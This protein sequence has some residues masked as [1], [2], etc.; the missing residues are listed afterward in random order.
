[1]QATAL[2]NEPFVAPAVET[3]PAPTTVELDPRT[4]PLEGIS[5]IEASAGT[6]KTYNLTA[7]VVRF[8]IEGHYEI[9]QILVVTFTNAATEELRGRIRTRLRDCLRQARR[10]RDSMLPIDD[11]VLAYA[12]EELEIPSARIVRRLDEALKGFDES[13]TYTIHSFCQRMLQSNAFES[14]SLFDTELETDIQRILRPIC[15]DFWRR[16]ITPIDPPSF[17]QLQDQSL[18]ANAL[19]KLAD[20]STRVK[21]EVIPDSTS[22]AVQEATQ[23]YQATVK[24]LREEWSIDRVAVTSFLLEHNLKRNMY[25]LAMVKAWIE[26]MDAWLQPGVPLR[27]LQPK[28]LARFTIEALTK[29]LRKGK[30]KPTHYTFELCEAVGQAAD[31]LAGAMSASIIALKQDLL[32]YTRNEQKSRKRQHNLVFYDD[33]LANLDR[34]LAGNAGKRL[35]EA[36][37][38]KFPVALIDEFQDTDPIQYAIFCRVYAETENPLFLIGDPKQSIYGFRGADIFAYMRAK[39]QAG[40]KYTLSMNWRSDPGLISGVN[41]IFRGATFPFFYENLHFHLALPADK[42]DREALLEEGEKSSPLRVWFLRRNGRE[43]DRHLTKTSARK[44]ISEATSQEICRL[45]SMGEQSKALIGRKPVSAGDIAVLV[46]NR[47]DAGTIQESLHKY[48][49]PCVIQTEMRVLQTDEA[50]E[51]ER[52][53]SAVARPGEEA[54]LR[55]ALL[56]D[57]FGLDAVSLQAMQEDESAWE[58][59]IQMFR[60]YHD[61]WKE[62]GFIQ[63]FRSLFVREHV[64]KRVLSMPN[65]ERRLTNYLHSS[66][67]LQ[68]AAL[69]IKTGMNG[70]VKWLNENREKSQ[71]DEHLLRLESDENR[72]RIVTIHKS[73]GLEYPIVFLPDP[74][75]WAYQSAG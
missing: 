25:S 54:R 38:E 8:I 32:S 58:T 20:F 72:V 6:G 37:R 18:T 39:E 28:K 11:E 71:E 75:G 10:Y 9:D 63:M 41:A 2:Q 34:A 60:T 52:V 17:R 23:V 19:Q 74:L 24:E 45:I 5:I 57:I 26:E 73:K 69:E 56:T 22:S 15:D 67:I 27:H 3:V 42:K 35:A 65:G 46:R 50:R 68:E 61:T 53:L 30:E 33:L 40:Q 70:L 44:C 43:Q 7:F 59:R 1:M 47:Y 12:V 13:A 55:S 36:M 66:E 51:I 49:V 48:K 64:A 29:G 31:D 21:L 62:R 16:N 4:A 14:G